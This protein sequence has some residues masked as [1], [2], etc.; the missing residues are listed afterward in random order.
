M[1]VHWRKPLLSTSIKDPGEL[2]RNL[3]TREDFHSPSP[4][5]EANQQQVYTAELLWSATC[6]ELRL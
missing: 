6:V 2:Q 3:R 4:L 5:P 1:P